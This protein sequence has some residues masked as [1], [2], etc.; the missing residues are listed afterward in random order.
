MSSLLARAPRG[1][2]ALA[3][4]LAALASLAI[5]FTATGTQV[6]V[7]DG[8]LSVRQPSWFET[9]GWWGIAILL[10]FVGLYAAPGLLY[11]RGWR[12]AAVLSAAAAIVLTILASMS[13]GLFYYP[14][15][16][17]TLLALLSMPF[18]TR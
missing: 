15:G 11:R 3:A 17:V 14:A 1:L 16:L 5:L 13:I 18:D 8:V 6:S 7:Q 12:A 9:Q 4:G 2:L 10:I